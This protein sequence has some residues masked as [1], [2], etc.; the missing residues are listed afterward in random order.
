MLEFV[1]GCDK[2][3]QHFLTNKYEPRKALVCVNRHKNQSL[4]KAP[5]LPFPHTTNLTWID[6][7]SLQYSDISCR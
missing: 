1:V 6:S 7:I 2:H 5:F 3:V 4:H